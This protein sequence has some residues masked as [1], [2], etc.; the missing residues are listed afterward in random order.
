[1]HLIRTLS[2]PATGPAEHVIHGHTCL[3]S[4]EHLRFNLCHL[5]YNVGKTEENNEQL[6]GEAIRG[7]PRDRLVIAT[8]V[9][10]HCIS[11]SRADICVTAGYATR[12]VFLLYSGASSWTVGHLRMM[13]LASTA[14]VQATP[15]IDQ[16]LA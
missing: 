5:Q 6:L 1:M 4:P 11:Q 3:R 7:H 16:L 13:A 12:L 2:L 9:S 15:H 8:K 14:G 10:P